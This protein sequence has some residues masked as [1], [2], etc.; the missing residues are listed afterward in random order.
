MLPELG[1]KAGVLGIELDASYVI[2]E[3][4]LVT[5]WISGTL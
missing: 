1:R 2:E 4:G 5:G 3:V